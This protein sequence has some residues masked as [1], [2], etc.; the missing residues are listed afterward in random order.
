MVCLEN[1]CSAHVCV[2]VAEN[3][4]KDS[5]AVMGEHEHE[6]RFSWLDHNHSAS[7]KF[8]DADDSEYEVRALRHRLYRVQLK[9]LPM[10]FY[11]NTVPSV[12]G[13]HW[14]NAGKDGRPVK[15]CLT[16]HRFTF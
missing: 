3:L 8:V 15:C 13:H 10:S 11:F 6:P 16:P 1:V 12:L 7:V 5:F 14:L 9:Y 4:L 2:C